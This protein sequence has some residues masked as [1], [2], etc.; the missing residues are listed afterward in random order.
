VVDYIIQT[1]EQA[2][3]ANYDN[4][5]RG[6]SPVDGKRIKGRKFPGD[7][8]WVD[9]NGD[10][11][12]DSKDQ[13]EI[14]VTVP[15]T[16]GG[17]ANNF[18]YKNWSLNLYL[19]WAIGHSIN[20]EAYMRFFMNTFAYNY[21]LVEQAKDTWTPENTDATYARITANDPGD[22]SNNF[23]RTSSAFNFKADYLCI[24]EV[25]LNY[26]VP[27]SLFSAIGIQNASVYISGNNLHYF[28]SLIGTSPERGAS[29][30]YSN[31]D[32]NNY[33]SIRKYSLGVKVTF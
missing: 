24:R 18:K 20:D 2:D 27:T 28:T 23:A 13:F 10:G 7:Y 16:T 26:D 22:A 19:D 15:H 12:I 3:N 4:S 33:P 8:E 5:S 32:Y 31:N 11:I 9:R 14:G 17:L 6:F 29:T 30:T 25:T 21:A 1:Q